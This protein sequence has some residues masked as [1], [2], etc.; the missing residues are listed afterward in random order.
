ML[1]M[2]LIIATV[3]PVTADISAGALPG[4]LPLLAS[5]RHVDARS[6]SQWVTVPVAVC[7]SV[8]ESYYSLR[9]LSEGLS[10]P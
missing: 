1:Y 4:G 5:Q 10:K 7:K 6:T 2:L 8:S 3:R 9:P